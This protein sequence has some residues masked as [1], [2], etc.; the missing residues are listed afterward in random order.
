MKRP[1]A[2]RE[3]HVP[4]KRDICFYLLQGTNPNTD[5]IS[6]LSRQ[7]RF[8]AFNLFYWNQGLVHVHPE[9]FTKIS[10]L[11]FSAETCSSGSIQQ[12]LDCHPR[13]YKPNLLQPDVFQVHFANH[14]NRVQRTLPGASTWSTNLRARSKLFCSVVRHR[15]SRASDR[16]S[17]V[18]RSR[19]KRR[20]CSLRSNQALVPG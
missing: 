16:N 7:S 15:L 6:A 5:L 14:R 12:V 8:V 10:S 11:S 13:R 4:C 2:L 19:A 3:H 1:S 9:C 20:C 17:S 18:P